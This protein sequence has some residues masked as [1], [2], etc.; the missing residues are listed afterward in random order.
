[1]WMRPGLEDQ[2]AH[3]PMAFPL[4][5]SLLRIFFMALCCRYCRIGDLWCHRALLLLQT[6]PEEPWNNVLVVWLIM[7]VDCACTVGVESEPYIELFS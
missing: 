6:H 2:T 5:R 4:S 3:L 7:M 1:M